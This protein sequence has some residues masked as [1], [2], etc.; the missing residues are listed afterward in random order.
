MRSNWLYLARRSDLDTM[1]QLDLQQPECFRLQDL[2]VK[3]E[4]QEKT[5]APLKSS[6]PAPW[7][8]K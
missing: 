4:V 7:G 6:A 2:T 1:H 8:R 5:E 3:R